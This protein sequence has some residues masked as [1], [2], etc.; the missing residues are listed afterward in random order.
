[1]KRLL[2]IVLSVFVMFS[3]LTSYSPNALAYVSVKGYYRSNGTYVK[4]YVRSNPNGLKTDNYGYT[5][6][7]GQYNPT[8]GTKGA[9]W[10]T[11]TT[12]TDPNYYQG[13][14]IYDN[15]QIGAN[16]VL[17]TPTASPDLKTLYTI[18]THS[19]SSDKY[20]RKY[21]Q[22][23]RYIFT[24]YIPASKSVSLIFKAETDSKVYTMDANQCL[25]WMKDEKVAIRLYGSTWSKYVN[26]FDDG[27][28]VG[29]K[30]C[31]PIT[32]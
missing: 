15:N 6:S 27:I 11:P 4:P 28:F 14:Q 30:I 8:Y 1:M 24:Q 3:A 17:S 5:P 12:I 22:D 7:Q 2:L 19:T 25:R 16:N 32:E 29:Y 13:K 31:E 9:T 20:D 18:P 23:G 21:A 10:D 26:E